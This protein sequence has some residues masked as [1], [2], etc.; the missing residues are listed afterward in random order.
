M[1]PGALMPG[2]SFA[3]K[4]VGVIGLPIK[5]GSRSSSRREVVLGLTIMSVKYSPMVQMI[6]ITISR[7]IMLRDDL[8]AGLFADIITSLHC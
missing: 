8:F 5:A 2:N 6:K 7:Y 4:S 1:T 3:G